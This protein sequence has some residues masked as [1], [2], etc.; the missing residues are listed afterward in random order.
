MS[1][2]APVDF[3]SVK[4]LTNLNEINRALHETVARERSIE[5]ELE[6]L[7]SK[8][9][10]IEKGFVNL[11]DSASDVLESLLSDAQ[12]LAAS[13]HSTSEL[14]EGVSFKVRELDTAQSRIDDTLQR[15]SI[16]VDRS[17]AVEGIRA[18]LEVGDYETAAEHVSKYLELERRFGTMADEVENRQLQDQRREAKV[19]LRQEIQTRLDEAKQKGDHKAVLRFTRL[20]APLGLQASEGLQAFLVYLRDL[21]SRRAEEDYTSLVEGGEQAESEY[22]GTLTNL[23]KDV[24]VAVDENE[25]FVSGT[26]GPEAAVEAILG[27]QQLCDQHG[28]KIMQRYIKFRRLQQ[29][30]GEIGTLSVAKRTSAPAQ[31]SLAVDPRQ[32]EGYL[33]EMLLLCQ[34]SE[35][36]NQ[37]M[38]AKLTAA[39]A[40]SG[41][42][43]ADAASLENSFRSGQ[44][45][46]TVRE[47]IAYYINLEEFYLEEN[48]GKAIAIDEWSADALTTSMVDDVFFILQKC[49]RRALATGNLQCLC[50][51][52][53]Q[54]N[55]LLS[56]SLR[57]ALEL[58]WKVLLL[59]HAPCF[60]APTGNP[61]EYAA[62]F[63][64]A[65]VSATYVGKL[66]EELED[67][68]YHFFGSSNER[69][70]IKS[71]LADLSKTSSD[72]A[73]I[74]A[75]ALEQLS[76]AIVP[77]LRAML[78]EAAGASYEL[79]EE[80]YARNEVEDTWVQALLA[81]LCAI[82]QWLQPFLTPNNY[83]ALKSDCALPFGQVVERVEA[84]LRLKP[85]NQL[86]GLQLDRDVRALV[87]TLSNVTQRTVRDKFAILNQMG[88][89]LSLES[90]SEVM[91]YWGH[92]AGPI[93]W[94]LT[95]A[96]VKEVLGQRT[97]F[98][99]HEI[100]ALDL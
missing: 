78:D 79:S 8:R 29:L 96:Q 84:T 67:S 49:G 54:I 37:F 16:V 48:V 56:N 6:Q 93:T 98:E 99:P 85:F 59:Q 24:A 35:E 21:I 34:R 55:N 36:Y 81:M 74:T 97:D 68:S 63:N 45:N 57:T 77:R 2:L 100:A 60:F 86:G 11:H 42:P 30:M 71:V 62:V 53:G 4:R 61:A 3:N 25:Q 87:A 88:T 83:D 65:D 69:E 27:L 15:I 32:I 50:A 33:E 17:N 1:V 19:R 26:F 44:F 95:E 94:R 39:A 58:N 10:E 12:Q 47:L 41:S 76:T 92:N 51:I 73:H 31:A 72:F 28:T 43:K 90:V 38:L 66:R 52:L 14:S 7:L 75:R 23:F 22:V 89:L 18:A 40:G 9:A 13:V 5:A 20:F 91:D 82:L 64:N 46:V 80:E 70:R